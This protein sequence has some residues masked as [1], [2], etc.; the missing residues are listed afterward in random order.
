MKTTPHPCLT[1]T[2]AA[3]ALLLLCAAGLSAAPGLRR[4]IWDNLDG[5]AEVQL[6]DRPSF[7]G[8]PLTLTTSEAFYGPPATADILASALSPNLYGGSYGARLRG[9]L[10]APATGDYIFS[11]GGPDT[12]AVYLSNDENPTGKRLILAHSG[13]AIGQV[14]AFPQ[15]SMPLHLE[16]RR[17]YYLEVIQKSDATNGDVALSW[18]TPG[19][20]Q[21]II[22][23]SA[24]ETY[25]P[26]APNPAGLTREFFPNIKGSGLDDLTAAPAFYRIPARTD[27]ITS[28]SYSGLGEN[29]GVRLRGYLTAPATGD[30]T[31]WECGSGDVSLCLA[32]DENA[33]A[34]HQSIRLNDRSNKKEIAHHKG[35]TAPLEWDKY[36]NQPSQP[37]KL[38]AG[39]KYYLEVSF[40]AGEGADHLAI[41]WQVPGRK[42]ELLPPSALESYRRAP[43]DF[44]DDG[45]PDA[46]ERAAKLDPTDAADASGDLDGDG[47]FN[48]EAIR[49]GANP[50]A[51]GS[52][53]GIV[54]DDRWNGLPG[55][56][57]DQ[58]AYRAAYTRPLSERSASVAMLVQGGGANFVRRIRGYLTAPMSGAYTFWAGAT[59]DSA[60][61]LST[62]ASKFDRQPLI[63]TA[64][65]IPYGR[66]DDN[67][68]QKSP[69]VTL[70][71]GEKY[72]FEV[73]HKQ[74]DNHAALTV[75]WQIPGEPRQ[76]IPARYLSS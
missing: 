3:A 24:L 58:A 55:E 10:T 12:V 68:T 44:D 32:T 45:M 11:E 6:S 57:L 26:P 16:A 72:Y 5:P 46:L 50:A 18:Q 7:F 60:L 21:Q 62:T 61:S 13:L 48:D 30:Y 56:I 70:M 22:P 38:I 36:R 34:L 43:T 42:P 23:M 51:R 69:T 31:F 27:I 15:R 8:P 25:T 66:L 17:K 20:L 2:R 4:E 65:R 73:W 53:N 37:I 74:G 47:I 54:L 64:G 19:G 1:P 35:A 75:A 33:T 14:R 49:A 39:K 63:K 71:G 40:K 67:A 41:A 9:Y 29:Y 28:S 59:G 76:T 52:V